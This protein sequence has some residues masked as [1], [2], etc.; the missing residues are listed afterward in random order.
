MI[1]NKSHKYPVS[2]LCKVLQL[3]RSTYYYEVKQK[4]DESSLAANIVDIFKASRN[5]YGTH[6][7]K[8]ELKKQDIIVSRRYVGR[9]MKR[10]GLMSNYTVA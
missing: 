3:S 1:R 8:L 2:A 7:I 9:I 5:N 10:E 6:K 4:K